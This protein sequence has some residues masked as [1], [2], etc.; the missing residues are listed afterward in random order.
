MMNSRVNSGRGRRLALSVCAAGLAAAVSGCGIPL[1]PVTLAEGVVVEEPIE[2]AHPIELDA[3]RIDQ[4]VPIV[5]QHPVPIALPAEMPPITIQLQGPQV[6]HRG[7]YVSEALMQRIQIGITDAEWIV[8]V[9]GQ[10]DSRHPMSDGTEIWKWVYRPS[11]SQQPLI[12]VL[13]TDDRRPDPQP[14]TA[15]V[16]LREGIVV[17]KWRG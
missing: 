14:I 15:Y 7:T 9:V 1:A 4:T 12:D 3:L 13:G 2:I 8:A 17:D 11:A 5:I 6:E 16:R 10:P